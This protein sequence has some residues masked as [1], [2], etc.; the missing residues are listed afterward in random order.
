MRGA[1]YALGHVSPVGGIIPA[2]AG[3][4]SALLNIARPMTDHPRVCGEHRQR[5]WESAWPS[6]SSPRMRGAPHVGEVCWSYRGIIPAYAGSTGN[7]QKCRSTCGDHPRVCGEHERLDHQ[8]VRRSGSSPRM[9]GAPLLRQSGTW[10]SGII[11]AY[12]GSTLPAVCFRCCRWDHPR[13]CGEHAIVAARALYDAGSSPR[14]RGAPNGGS[15]DGLLRG[16]IPAYAGSTLPAVCFRC[17]RWDHPRVC[18][19]HVYLNEG[20]EAKVGSSPRMRGAPKLSG[21]VWVKYGIIPAYAGSTSVV[22]GNFCHEWDHPRV[23]GEHLPPFGNSCH[24]GGSSPRMRG[25][26]NA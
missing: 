3:S 17:C 14:M 26:Q 5:R 19:E 25:A 13:V 23:C 18:G 7:I 21:R 9:R 6:G 12:A 1:R 4:T 8:Q 15:S 2:Y 24:S 22:I 11:P 16:I 10:P 20:R